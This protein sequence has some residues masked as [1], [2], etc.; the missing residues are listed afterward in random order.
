MD[1]TEA[2]KYKTCVKTIKKK[3]VLREPKGFGKV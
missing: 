3:N 1:G 2:V